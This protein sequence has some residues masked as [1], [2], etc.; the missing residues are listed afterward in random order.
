MEQVDK[1]MK[2]DGS[3]NLS[4]ADAP[5]GLFTQTGWYINKCFKK[6][7]IDGVLW[8]YLQN[9]ILIYWGCTFKQ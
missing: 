5:S 3:G 4:F 1:L 2:T 8:I 7:M 6:S 9:Y